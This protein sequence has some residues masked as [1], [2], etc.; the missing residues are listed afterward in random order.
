VALPLLL[1]AVG[2]LDGAR[3]PVT[4]AALGGGIA[5]T[6][7]AAG[8]VGAG[9]LTLSLT[10][11][12]VARWNGNLVALSPLALLP[13]VDAV[14]FAVGRASPRAR[15]RLARLVA[16]LVVP[17]AVDAIAH[18]LGL[19]HQRHL[20]LLAVIAAAYALSLAG[21]RRAALYSAP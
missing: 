17:I 13:L 5:L 3:R 1:L 19:A 11:Y 16:A 2:A 14:R 21:L 18:G 8:A 12:D 15:R 9:V 6:A 10:P 7:L 4:R 20:G